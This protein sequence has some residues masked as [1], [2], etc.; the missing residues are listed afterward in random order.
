M[1]AIYCSTQYLINGH[2]GGVTHA[3]TMLSAV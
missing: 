3:K 2:S 1:G